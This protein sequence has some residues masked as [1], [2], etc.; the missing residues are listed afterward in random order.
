MFGLFALGIISSASAECQAQWEQCGGQGYTGETCC[1]DGLSCQGSTWWKACLTNSVPTPHPSPA[2]TASPIPTPHPTPAPTQA[3]VTTPTDP[4]VEGDLSGNLMYADSSGAGHTWT[5]E[6]ITKD[7]FG[8]L[9]TAKEITYYAGESAASSSGVGGGNC[10][11]SN[12]QGLEAFDNVSGWVAVSKAKRY[13]HS[14][15]CGMCVQYR[16]LGGSNG[17]V[18]NPIPTTWQKAM[19]VDSCDACENASFN[20]PLVELDLG[21]STGDGRWNI[22]WQSVECDVGTGKFQYAFQGPGSNTWSIKIQIRNTKVPIYKVEMKGRKNVLDLTNNDSHYKYYE[23]RRSDDNHFLASQTHTPDLALVWNR[24]YGKYVGAVDNVSWGTYESKL[25]LR[26]TSIFG[27]V[28]EDEVNFTSPDH[29]KT[30]SYSSP[31]AG[32][33]QFTNGAD[34]RLDASLELE[35][36]P[37]PQA[38]E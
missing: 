15:A 31:L 12:V 26:I 8:N 10:A 1:Q 34:R 35:A 11:F 20:K 25:E 37:R 16:G 2:P 36:P 38:S 33:V 6:Y 17:G 4:P 18:D 13:D 3:P 27:E 24:P 5:P 9:R 29:L 23:M 22:E 28:V 14:M 30:L 19:V 21:D 32:N 7:T